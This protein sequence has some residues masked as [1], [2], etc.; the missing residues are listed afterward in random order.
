VI[1]S[2][3]PHWVS[4]KDANGKRKSLNLPDTW[5]TD[6]SVPI[7][8]ER[9]IAKSLKSASIVDSA[10]YA[11]GVCGG[12]ETNYAYISKNG[13]IPNLTDSNKFLEFVRSKVATYIS[14]GRYPGTMDDGPLIVA[15][16]DPHFAM[17]RFTVAV[18]SDVSRGPQAV[19]TW[20]RFDL[21][22][23]LYQS[24]PTDFVV[25]VHAEDLRTAPK[26]ALRGNPPTVE[27]FRPI[28]SAAERYD[29]EN[30]VAAGVARFL[31]GSSSRCRAQNDG[32]DASTDGPF[33]CSK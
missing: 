32:F 12:T 18:T 30:I 27:H 9:F 15:P 28:G 14:G 24:T 2:K 8:S 6:I 31:A 11:Q 19:G 23:A 33:Q 29:P 1:K 4:V 25:A 20:D 7:G 26:T 21:V 16:I 13:A 22:L 5:D 17:K 10:T 3:K